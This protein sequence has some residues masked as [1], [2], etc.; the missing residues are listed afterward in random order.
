MK[1]RCFA[2]IYTTARSEPV[3]RAL[4]MVREEHGQA[5][6]GTGHVEIG[7]ELL[8]IVI[9]RAGI[10]VHIALPIDNYGRVPSGR[11]QRVGNPRDRRL[12]AVSGARVA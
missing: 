11:G 4:D 12:L 9:E 6:L 2:S 7:A 5:G 8:A 3:F 1:G 10:R